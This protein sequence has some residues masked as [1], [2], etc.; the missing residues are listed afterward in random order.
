MTPGETARILI[1]DDEP[2]ICEILSRV[3]GSEGYTCEVASNGEAAIKW[4][5]NETFHL[6]ISDI[7]MPGLSGMDLLAIVK[8]LLPGRSSNHVDSR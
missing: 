4:L 8:A 3:L 7:M 5:E 1:V 6:L 2:Y